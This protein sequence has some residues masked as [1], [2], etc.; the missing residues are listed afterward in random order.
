MTP[1]LGILL[2]IFRLLTLFPYRIQTPL[3]LYQQLKPCQN[4]E[5]K[6]YDFVW[7]FFIEHTTQKVNYIVKIFLRGIIYLRWRMLDWWNEQIC[8]PSRDGLLSHNF[9]MSRSLPENALHEWLCRKQERPHQSNS[10]SQWVFWNFLLLGIL[11]RVFTKTLLT[12]TMSC[13]F[14]I[15][16]GCILKTHSFLP[17]VVKT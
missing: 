6:L 5:I 2:R 16:S 17:V 7:D 4:R 10:P 15:Y 11:L 12:A 13:N 14:W 3:L 1:V 9:H 8:K